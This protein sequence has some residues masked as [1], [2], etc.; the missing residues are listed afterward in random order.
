MRK[1]IVGFIVITA[2]AVGMALSL[3]GCGGTSPTKTAAAFLDAL[4]TQDTATISQLIS[5]S[6]DLESTLGDLL[7]DESSGS[8]EA[9]KSII[10]KM[11]DFDYRI[12]GEKVE[13]NTATIDV[14]LKTYEI[15]KALKSAVSSALPSMFTLAL[16]SA[17]Q[18]TITGVFYDELA[19]QFDGLTEKKLETSTTL[20]LK[21]KGNEWKFDNFSDENID[22][23]FGGIMAAVDDLENLW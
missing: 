21:K 6:D 8:S 14:E 11:C 22:A 15:G 7:N 4:K 3:C 9:M 5:S 10:A 1:R 16:T 17:D 18:D 2:L 23:V 12:T 20:T 13:G 19:K